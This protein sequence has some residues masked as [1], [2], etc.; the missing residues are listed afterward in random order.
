MIHR[1]Q[2]RLLLAFIAVILAAIGKVSFFVIRNTGSELQQFEER[3]NQ[4]RA[5]RMEFLLSSYHFIAGG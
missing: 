1:L 5:A 4:I 2:F 3:N